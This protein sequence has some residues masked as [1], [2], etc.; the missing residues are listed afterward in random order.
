[1][2]TSD[3]D[4]IEW[5]PEVIVGLS[6]KERSKFADKIAEILDDL[7]SEAV[8]HQWSRWMHGYWRNRLSSIPTQLSFDESTAMAGWIPF[9]RESFESGVQ[10][11]TSRPGR[12]RDHDDVLRHLERRVDDAP[13]A[14]AKVIGH[15]MR[16]TEQPWWAGHQ[17][18]ELMPRLRAGSDPAHISVIVE[19]AIRLGLSNPDE[20]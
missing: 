4:P 18:Q 5:L 11:V 8:E 10:L 13:D 9:L 2:L 17:L 7:P 15:L 16:S 1:A 6:N 12:F 20:W 19:Q 3:R 14:C